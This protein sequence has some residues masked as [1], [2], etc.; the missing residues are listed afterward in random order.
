MVNHINI[1][2]LSD[3]TSCH[4]PYDGGYCPQGLTFE[5]RTEMLNHDHEKF[6][7]LVDQSLTKHFHLIRILVER[8]AYFFDYGNAFMKAVFDAGNKDIAKNGKDTTEGFIFPSY[9]ED[10]LGPELFDY[11]NSLLCPSIWPLIFRKVIPGRK[12]KITRKYS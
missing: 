7:E 12:S 5:Q 10:I 9:V 2:L 8:G 11:T 6:C 3:Q 4:V 1:E